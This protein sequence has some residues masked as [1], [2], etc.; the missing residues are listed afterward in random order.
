M[1]IKISEKEWVNLNI[2]RLVFVNGSAGNWSIFFFYE[3]EKH[4]LSGY[5]SEDEAREVLDDIWDVYEKGQHFWEQEPKEILN[6]KLGNRWYAENEAINTFIRVIGRL[7]I[8]KVKE[9]E[10]THDDRLI[11]TTDKS[12]KRIDIERWGYYILKLERP[13]T[14]R[15]VLENI[16]SKLGVEI[17]V[18]IHR[19]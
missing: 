7:G 1:F 8:E 15:E 2:C 12:K 17:K 13:D 3:S 16:A 5:K 10:I 18:T 6:V 11:V 9:L 14:M 19:R 4:K